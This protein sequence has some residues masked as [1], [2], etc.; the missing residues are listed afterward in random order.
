VPCSAPLCPPFPHHTQEAERPKLLERLGKWKA[1]ALQQLLDVFDLPTPSKGTKVRRD[2]PAPEQQQQQQQ[3]HAA[4]SNLGAVMR[5]L[6]C[7]LTQI[8][9]ARHLTHPNHHHPHTQEEKMERVVSFLEKPHKA[10]DKDLAAKVGGV[11]VRGWVCAETHSEGKRKQPGM[12][13]HTW[14]ETAMF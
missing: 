13:G 9:P 11:R 14:V 5:A 4:P 1:E 2:R 12:T 3:Q 8:L 7:S 10:S 6:S